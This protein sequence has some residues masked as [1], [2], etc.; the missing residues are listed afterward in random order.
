MLVLDTNVI[1][2]LRKRPSR[3]DA[4]VA[5]WA[6]SVDFETVFLTVVT[7]L[8]LEI[9]ILRIGR[10]DKA[11]ADS[12]RRWVDE[13]VI[14]TFRGRI[15]PFDDKAA[16]ACAA[17]HV[18]NPMPD[19]DAFIA[20]IALVHDATVVTRNVTDFARAGVKL[21]NPWDAT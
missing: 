5:L 9:G 14:D 19:R 1:S 20:A 17:L 15:L 4:Q 21:L 3:V 12:L 18:P 8:E 6:A 16:L 7:L 11:Q 10:R 13:R 2:E